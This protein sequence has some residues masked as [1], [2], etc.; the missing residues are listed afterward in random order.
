MKTL[1][2]VKIS[3]NL[4]YHINNGISLSECIFRYGS[5]SHIDLIKEVREL[6]HRGE[7]LLEGRDKVIASLKTGEPALYKGRRVKLHLPQYDSD[8][9]KKF[10]VYLETG[11]TDE[12]SGLPIA[13]TLRFGDPDLK[14]KNNDKKAADNFQARMQCDSKTDIEAAGFWACNIALWA[15]HLGLASKYPW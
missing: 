12:E 6:Y 1:N 15:E 13:K 3:E 7:I 10:V 8:S 11:K 9:D 4:K 2:E 14:I 5:D